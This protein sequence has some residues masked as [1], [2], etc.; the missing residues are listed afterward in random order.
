MSFAP[1]M[2]SLLVPPMAVA[3]IAPPMTAAPLDP[4]FPANT[5]NNMVSFEDASTMYS[6][7]T[8]GDIEICEQPSETSE[9]AVTN[10][11][12]PMLFPNSIPLSE[13]ELDIINHLT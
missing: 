9:N 2:A 3:P 5:I 12:A 7:A 1:I 11:F 6:L 13:D 8:S 4:P 10:S